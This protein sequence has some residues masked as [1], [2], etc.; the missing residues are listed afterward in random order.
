MLRQSCSPAGSGGS[1]PGAHQL[2]P[3]ASPTALSSGAIA[4]AI[5]TFWGSL[6][7]AFAAY[8]QYECLRAHGVPHDIAL[9]TALGCPGGDDSARASRHLSCLPG[10]A[11]SDVPSP[12]SAARIGNLAF[13]P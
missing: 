1:A 8:R 7:E 10:D 12:P 6:R 13:V 5:R 2:L 11:R 3:S 4:T 9:R